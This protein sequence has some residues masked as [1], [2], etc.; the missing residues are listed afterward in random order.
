MSPVVEY[1]LLPLIALYCYMMLVYVIAPILSLMWHGVRG[2][3]SMQYRKYGIWRCY[4]ELATYGNHGLRNGDSVFG[5]SEQEATA[6]IEG[7]PW[8]SKDD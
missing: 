1:V 5:L 6:F 3:R 7:L 8:Y 4:K 2:V